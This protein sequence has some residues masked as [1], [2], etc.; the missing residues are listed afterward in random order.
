MSRAD[1]TLHAASQIAEILEERGIKTALIGAMALAFHGYVRATDDIDLAV[2]QP[3]LELRLALRTLEDRGFSFDLVNPE[4]GDPLGGVATL[5]KSGLDPIQLVNFSNFESPHNPL[6]GKY[7]IDN[8]LEDQIEGTALRVAD[9]P[10]LVALKLYA[11]GRKGQH[12][13]L[14]LLEARPDADL[15]EVRR[16]CE[17]SRLGDQLARLLSL[18]ADES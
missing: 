9:L 3:L 10:H 14:E 1:D 15:A 2:H 6:V 11:E 7:A 16:V 18:L 17:A 8:A 12:D 13:L 4:A 5:H